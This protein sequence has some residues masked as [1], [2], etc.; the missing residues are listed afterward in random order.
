MQA[1]ALV[2]KVPVAWIFAPL[3]IC[4][5]ALR[6]R[7]TQRLCEASARDTQ[8]VSHL[9][10]THTQAQFMKPAPVQRENCCKLAPV[11]QLCKLSRAIIPSANTDESLPSCDPLVF[12][13]ACNCCLSLHLTLFCLHC[14][15][16]APRT[17]RAPLSSLKQFGV[18][19]FRKRQP[20]TDGNTK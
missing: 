19:I 18:A 16:R 5:V 8:S 12:I 6:F 2:C 13:L 3:A 4:C 14:L 15:C 20:M 9:A 1:S 7:R 10:H 11:T 17:P